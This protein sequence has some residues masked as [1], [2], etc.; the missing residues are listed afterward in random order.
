M[1]FG[2]ERVLSLLALVPLAALLL[3]L[4]LRRRRRL[5]RRF[6]EWSQVERLM[7]GARLRLPALRAA[8]WTAALALLLLAL[9]RP[10]F[11]E[12]E[13]TI[14]ARG[15]DV[16]LAVDTSNSML[17]TD[18]QPTRMERA[19]AQLAALL[20]RLRGHRI[21]LISFA[22]A[23]M[24]N[25]PLTLDQ[26]IL[27]QMLGVVDANA[28][29]VPGTAIAEAVRLAVRSFDDSSPRHRVLVLLTDGEDHAGAI[30]EAAREAA[31]A[32][33]AIFAIGVG[34]TAGAAI[35]QFDA[36]GR[37][38][39]FR[40][41]ADG[42]PLL[43]RLQGDT[44]RQLAEATGGRA[45]VT[46]NL[47]Q[48][49]VD[50]IA[51][52]IERLP[53]RA[54]EEEQVKHH[55]E[56]FQAFL[57][58]A[59][60]L[61]VIDP[62]LPGRRRRRRV[63]VAVPAPAAAA[64]LL[65]LGASAVRAEEAAA[66]NN[67]GVRLYR[68]GQL[69][70]ALERFHQADVADPGNPAVAL[71]IGT[72]R[73]HQDQLEEAVRQFDRAAAA[74]DTALRAA[75]HYNRGTAEVRLAQRAAEQGDLGTA[76]RTIDQAIASLRGALTEVA[77][78]VEAKFNLELALRLRDQWRQQQQEQEQQQSQEQSQQQSQRGQQDQEQ[79]S[80]EQQ[81]QEQQ[82][83]EQ[84]E[85]QQSQDQQQ[86]DS[87]QQHQRSGEGQADQQQQQSPQ[88][89][90]DQQRS[91]DQH[92]QQQHQQPPPDPNAARAL[93]EQGGAAAQ[94]P[95]TP[96]EAM[97]QGQRERAEFYLDTLPFQEYPLGMRN[98]MGLDQLPVAAGGPDW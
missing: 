94:P 59:I 9:A 63:P 4:S 67:E 45:F 92:S 47:G 31:E 13:E 5:L 21:G 81:S 41:D 89:Q 26:T 98:L 69:D 6:G 61:L 22:G 77:G 1:I 30:R 76:L 56:Q 46:S 95:L 34:T 23:A 75:A 87:Q 8:L 29:G 18:V 38:V 91:Q 37:Q 64:L 14:L 88:G 57:L 10:Q 79:Q 48:V 54:L 78:D 73:F 74:A 62:L 84:R 16:I 49:E 28:V 52:E 53:Q 96:E 51:R 12:V 82:S 50:A 27:H 60:A 71:N 15:V 80:Q 35:P 93:S 2:E 68:E 17:A 40:Q 33:V 24:L 66:P 43:T 90:P 25:C 72:V 36:W 55:E 39:G 85:Q 58:P 65:L 44:L 70:Q 7:T 20:S 42:A 19:K 3:A 11:G 83:Q 97:R 86:S 32:K